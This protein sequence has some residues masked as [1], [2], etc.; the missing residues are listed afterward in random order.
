MKIDLNRQAA[1]SGAPLLPRTVDAGSPLGRSGLVVAGLLA[2]GL[3]LGSC[4]GG[5]EADVDAGEGGG[6]AEAGEGSAEQ[7]AVELEAGSDT[8]FLGGSERLNTGVDLTQ[9]N[10]GTSPVTSSPT[11][12][13]PIA[14]RNAVP[15]HL[16]LGEN[17]LQEFDF[18]QLHQGDV[19][20]HNFILRSDGDAPLVITRLKPSCGCTIAEIVILGEEGERTVYRTGEAIPPNTSFEIVAELNTAGKSGAVNTTVA[21]YSNDPRAVFNLG[22]KAEVR[23]MLVVEPQTTIPF[24]QMTTEQSATNTVQVVS[25]VLDPFLLSLDERYIEDQPVQVELT[26]IEPNAEG[27]STKWDVAVTVGPNLTREGI[28]NFPVVLNT[29][30]E[31]DNAQNPNPDGTPVYHQA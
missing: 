18:G 31:V 17:Q 25:D 11:N 2:A 21:V 9:L 23:P 30:V 3:L 16:T 7:E 8:S 24:G 19:G 26:P 1:E 22:L 4:S 14:D 29:D 5:N 6:Q 10:A 12:F 28:N 27:R 13:D 20:S 15:G